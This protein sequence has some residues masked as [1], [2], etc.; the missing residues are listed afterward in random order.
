MGLTDL[1]ASI[2]TAANY[3]VIK[4]SDRRKGFHLKDDSCE[5]FSSADKHRN[6]IGEEEKAGMFEEL[7]LKVS[8]AIR[9]ILQGDLNPKPKDVK[10]CLSCAWRSLCRAPHLN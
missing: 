9:G 6:F 1:P 5:L 8:E 3:Y 4:E 7:R 2:V 10:T